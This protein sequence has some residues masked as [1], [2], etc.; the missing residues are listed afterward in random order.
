M[1]RIALRFDQ[2]P[3]SWHRVLSGLIAGALLPVAVLAVVFFPF[4]HFV[5]VIGVPLAMAVAL[6]L[7]LPLA[8]LLWVHDQLRLW[9][10]AAIGAVATELP[11]L[12]L[13]TSLVA[14]SITGI[15]SQDG[16]IESASNGV[17]Q[18]KDGILTPTGWWEMI[19]LPMIALALLGVLG[20]L[21][22]WVVTFGSLAPR[23]ARP[24]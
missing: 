24:A 13:N 23:P 3:G 21:L 20:A 9:K 18:V 14:N 4:T 12:A 19:L 1:S 11:F 5:I 10:A 22:A 6:V 17:W 15:A 2:S 16:L 7:V 8:R